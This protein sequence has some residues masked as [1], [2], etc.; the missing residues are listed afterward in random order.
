MPFL[1]K[2]KY[3]TLDDDESSNIDVR[4]GH[5]SLHRPYISLLVVAVT[6]ILSGFITALIVRK[7][8]CLPMIH[9][10]PSVKHAEHDFGLST[11]TTQGYQYTCG[12]SSSEA[13]ALGCTFDPLSVNWIPVECS[14]EGTDEWLE[15]TKAR[16]SM[17]FP[18]FKNFEGS[19]D[20]PDERALSLSADFH[21][22]KSWHLGHCIYLLQR[23]HMGY[24]TSARVDSDTTNIIHTKHCLKMLME[25]VMKDKDRDTID[26][27]GEVGFLMC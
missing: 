23:L 4:R 3:A 15:F 18:F 5:S 25:V 21:T 19:V 22:T 20:I 6:A 1:S 26:T 14:R 11:S 17:K 24:L 13:M 8:S 9:A 16:P 7:A 27:H 10:S 2:E 12:N